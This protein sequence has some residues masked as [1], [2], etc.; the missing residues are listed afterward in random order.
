M[1]ADL[2]VPSS[3]M[4][5]CFHYFSA[6]PQS[7]YDSPDWISSMITSWERSLGSFANVPLLIACLEFFADGFQ[8]AVQSD[9]P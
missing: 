8:M 7:E 3:I 6:Y 1:V 2:R 9:A 4:L 5:Q